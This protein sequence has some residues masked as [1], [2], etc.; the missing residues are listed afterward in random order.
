M[1]EIE[2]YQS[3]LRKL[4]N[5]PQMYLSDVDNYLSGLMKEVEKPKS[6]NIAT[7]MAFAD[8]WSDMEE[9]DFVDFLTETRNIRNNLFDRKI[10]L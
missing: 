3:I 7:V 5:I 1:T 10:D 2:L 9:D 8:S 6:T 4:S